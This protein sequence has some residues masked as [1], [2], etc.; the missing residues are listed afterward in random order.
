MSAKGEKKESN[1][2][3]RF[4]IG[5]QAYKFP[6][7]LWRTEQRVAIARAFINNPPIII[8]DEPTEILTVT[9]IM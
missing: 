2:F 6:D 1:F 3:E 9:H 5:E 4:G 7:Q 8:A